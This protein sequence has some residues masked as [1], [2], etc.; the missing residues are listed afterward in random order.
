MN[1]LVIRIS[2]KISGAEI[3]NL[4]LLKELMKY[5]GFSFSVITNLRP[6]A[7]KLSFAASDVVCL[8]MLGREIG[9]KKDLL[10]V[11]LLLPIYWLLWLVNIHILETKSKI[12]L[13]CLQSMTEKIFLTPI[14]KFIGY[15]VIWIEHGPLYMSEKSRVV[16]WLYRVMSDFP[17]TIITVSK[18]TEADLLRGGVIFRKLKVVH[19]GIDTEKVKPLRE[20]KIEYIKRSLAIKPVSKIIGFLGTVTKEKGIEDFLEISL[21]LVRRGGD[22]YF[23]IIGDGPDLYWMKKQVKKQRIDSHYRFVGF[24]EDARSYLG[25]IDIFLFP[26]LHKEGISLAM[27]EAQSMEK[28]IVTRDIG[29]NSEIVKNSVNGFLYKDWDR[30][31]VS[32]QITKLFAN[33][34]VII[35]VGKEA[36]KNV[37]LRFNI[38]NQAKKFYDLFSSI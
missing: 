14:L 10:I 12:D 26:T 30:E 34:K 9:T 1:I 2:G 32:R 36:R 6:F 4:V 17:K 24:V 20:R 23:L 13:I 21:Q 5:K 31:V 27:L 19:I 11:L 29:G 37:I 33:S 3:Y 28:V 8:P 7:L 38:E 35:K 25:I 22:F 15:K 18:D 16:K